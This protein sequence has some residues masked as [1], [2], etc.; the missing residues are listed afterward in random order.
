[1]STASVFSILVI[2]V[3]LVIGAVAMKLKTP[4]LLAVIAGSMVGGLLGFFLF[5]CWG[6]CTRNLFRGEVEYEGKKI[7]LDLVMLL[8]ILSSGL[9][10]GLI[11]LVCRSSSDS[12]TKETP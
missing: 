12:K 6:V 1:M 2:L 3:F 9:M 7:N 10:G 11:G 8:F 4:K 5:C